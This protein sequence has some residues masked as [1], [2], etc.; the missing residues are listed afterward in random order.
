MKVKENQTF[1]D[2]PEFIWVWCGWGFLM[3]RFIIYHEIV[4]IN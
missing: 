3:M 1:K 4:N 2:A